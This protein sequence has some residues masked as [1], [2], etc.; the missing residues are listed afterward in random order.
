M[1]EKRRSG[2]TV[3][4]VTMGKMY[5]NLA[6]F[7]DGAAGGAS[8][9]AGAG[10]DGAAT[11]AAVQVQDGNPTG[12]TE[13]REAG[14]K[15]FKSKYKAE[16]DQDVQRLIARRYAEN[17]TLHKTLDSHNALLELLGNK[18]G[19]MA[20]EN[21]YSVEEITAAIE[22][23]NTFFEEMAMREGMPVEKYKEYAR[24]QRENSMLQ[25]AQQRAE[26]LQQ[27]EQIYRKWDEESQICK[28]KYPQFD[29]AEE[30]KN[31]LFLNLLS[32]GV[33]VENAYTVCH[34]DEIM[35]SIRQQ[36]EK[37]TKKMVADNIRSGA[38]RPAE[39]AAGTPAAGKQVRD[40]MG[41]TSAEFWEFRKK[42]ES[43]EISIS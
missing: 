10:G 12:E 38:A 25:A 16:F 17:Q 5:L 1:E 24:M 18:Y 11:G 40:I 23:D 19:V 42:V 6:M 43:G 28:A 30:S 32:N 13:D 15:E 35:Q 8:G 33:T 3:K 21:G 37:N 7:D 29:F 26:E 31:Q 27:R 9:A 36:T 39:A 2:E 4:E 41:M 14:Y 20:G 22:K 34:Q